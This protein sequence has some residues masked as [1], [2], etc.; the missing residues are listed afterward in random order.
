MGI[1]GYPD[2]DD[3]NTTDFSSD[4]SNYQDDNIQNID[5]TDEFLESEDLSFDE[6]A[7]A[8]ADIDDNLVD[9]EVVTETE[10]DT[11]I[12]EVDLTQGSTEDLSSTVEADTENVEDNVNLKSATSNKLVSYILIMALLV[13]AIGAYVYTQSPFALGGK[14]VVSEQ[15]DGDYFYDQALNA[16]GNDDDVTIP[17]QTGEPMAT[18]EVDLSTAPVA[19]VVPSQPTN[20]VKVVE[21][22]KVETVKVEDKKV[23]TKDK[24]V[25]KPDVVVEE[26]KPLNAFERAMAKSKIDEEKLSQIG[27]SNKSVVIPVISGGRPDPFLPSDSKL[28]QEQ[29]KFDLVAPPTTVPEADAKIDSLMSIKI[30]G[31]MYDNVRPSAIIVLDGNEQ[32][33][34]KGDYVMDYQVLDITKDKVLVKYKTNTF[35]ISAGQTVKHEG[36]NINP[37]SS[38][39]KQFGGVYSS[40]PEKAIQIK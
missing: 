27:L 24:V 2:N 9:D 30:T 36:V 28:A 11:V 19:N 1:L 31:I 35:E 40:N 4:V 6:Q 15:A 38:L 33:I 23:E 16:S 3:K 20:D 5:L 29:I 39:S 14:P 34:H 10:Q 13:V 8:A 12:E 26:K 21:P 17:A 32:L 18:V 25:K 7:A 22:S 37:V